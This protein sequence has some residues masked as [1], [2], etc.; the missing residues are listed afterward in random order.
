MKILRTIK[1]VS[2]REQIR[3]ETIRN[4]LQDIVRW[5]R[6]RRRQ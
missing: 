1:G 5:T 6:A 3:N 4:E 2:L